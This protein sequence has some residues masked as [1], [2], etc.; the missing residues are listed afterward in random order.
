MG[1]CLSTPG[2]AS[3]AGVSRGVSDDVGTTGTTAAAADVFVDPAYVPKFTPFTEEDAAWLASAQHAKMLD[4]SLR[5]IGVADRHPVTDRPRVL[6]TYPLRVMCDD[7]RSK[8]RGFS[9]NKW[10]GKHGTDPVPWPNTFWLCCPEY[11]ARVGTLEQ[12]GLIKSYQ[13]RLNNPPD[14]RAVADAEAFKA[15]HARYGAFRWSLLSPADVAYAEREGYTRVLRDFGVGGLRVNVQVKCLH[16][17]Y[18][19]HLAT[20]EN[21]VGGW[22]QRELDAAVDRGEGRDGS[23]TE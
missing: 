12:T 11:T 2:S 21:L 22:V 9:T 1:P 17:H 6:V 7:A 8:I 10:G 13:A 23:T 18:A 16:L 19:H 5:V 15:Q 3:G 4:R 20:G 14:A